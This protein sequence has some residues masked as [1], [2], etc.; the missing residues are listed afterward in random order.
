MIM[1]S[2]SIVAWI[3][4]VTGISSSGNL[5]AQQAFAQTQKSLDPDAI[6]SRFE[7]YDAATPPD[8]IRA[9]LDA[10][11]EHLKTNPALKGV[12]LSYGGKE[13]CRN[14]A[15]LRGRLVT[16]YLSKSRG[17]SSNHTTIRNAGYRD[18]WVIE[19]WVGSVGATQPPSTKTINK[20]RVRIKRHCHLTP[21]K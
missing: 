4:I 9:R 1:K 10:F 11:A 8:T 13:S 16:S 20:K 2:W 5:V 19:L 6:Y 17:V 21:I 14:E 15:V 12:V 18:H 3:A 7:D